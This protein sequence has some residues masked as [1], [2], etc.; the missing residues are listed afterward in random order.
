MMFDLPK[1]QSSIIKVI[2]VGGG[3]T[4]AVNHMYNQGIRGVDFVV[5][6]T[7]AQHLENSPVP[8]KVQ[9][10]VT[11]TEGLGAGSVPDMGRNA[12]LE[13]LDRV[14]EILEKNTKMVFIT[15]GMGGGTGTGAAPVIAALAKEMGILTVGIVT[16]PFSFEGKQRMAHAQRGIEELKQNVDTLVLICN[17]KLRDMHGNLGLKNAFG[18]A[19]DVLTT[20]AKGIAEVITVNGYINLDFNDVRTVMTNG[21]TAIMGYAFAEGDNRAMAVVEEALSCPLLNDNDIN[22]ASQVLLYINSGTE[23]EV[24]MDEISEISEYVQQTAGSNASIIFGAGYD[25]TLGSKLSAIVIATGFKPSNVMDDAPEMEEKK[26]FK[27][28]E[29]IKQEPIAEVVNPMEPVL[30]V[31]PEPTVEAVQEQQVDFTVNNPEV[32][33]N[34]LYDDM[35]QQEPAVNT[36]KENAVL[37]PQSEIEDSF[38]VSVR[39]DANSFEEQNSLAQTQIKNTRDRI[40]ELKSIS[41]QLK[42]KPKSVVEEEREPAYLRKGIEVTKVIPSS[43]SHISKYTL[44][45]GDENKGELKSRNSFL[46]DNVD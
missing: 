24:T 1:D 38:Q 45:E 23:S 10:G 18:H 36:Q 40:A 5:C 15:A 39:G 30:K 3:G 22:G 31:Y 4:N 41:K 7:D 16:T 35:Q 2:G 37:Q 11:L 44:S 17:E 9:I 14:R 26:K 13:N 43:E 29:E 21:G 8:T 32:I 46:H 34:N 19:D 42:E 33:V 20:A 6:N 12:A 27:L 25:E 28:N